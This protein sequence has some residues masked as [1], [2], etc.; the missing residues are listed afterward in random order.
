MKRFAEVGLAVRHLA[1][2]AT[3]AACGSPGGAVELLESETDPRLNSVLVSTRRAEPT[4]ELHSGRTLEPISQVSDFEP[5]LAEPAAAASADEA[6]AASE[7]QSEEQPG[8]ESTASASTASSK[9]AVSAPASPS[10]KTAS[11]PAKT[12]LT[13]AK[14]Q[15]AKTSSPPKTLAKDNGFTPRVATRVVEQP[16]TKSAGANGSTRP[17]RFNRV[18]PGVTTEDRLIVEW[19]EPADRSP[20]RGEL[21]GEV[22]TF[23]QPPF[24]AV[25]ALVRDG[26]V[27]V[28]RVTLAESSSIAD[29]TRKLK[30]S[31]VEPVDVIDPGA[32]TLLGVSFP[33]KGLTLLTGGR[34]TPGP[35]QIVKLVL[36]PRGPK[37]FTLRAENRPVTAIEKRLADLTAA[38][39]LDAKDPHAWWLKSLAHLDAGQ[40][41]DAVEAAVR[42]TEL[43]SKSAAYRLAE[44]RSLAIAGKLDA[45]VLTTRRVL[46]DGGASPIVRA[47]ALHTLGS[48]ASLGGASIAGKSIGFH[49]RAIE[50]ADELT[51]SR[52]P[53]VRRRAKRMLVD[54][55]LAIAVEI[56]RRD[57]KDRDALVADWIGRASG[58]AEAAIEAEDGGLELRLRVAREALTALA[59]MRPTK[60]PSP[61]ID[62]AKQTAEALLASSDDSLF[63]AGV[64]WDLGVAYKQAVR[65]EH[66]RADAAQALRFGSEAIDHLAEGAGPRVT[67]PGAERTVGELYFY[68]GAANAVH[69]EN[70]EE[71]VGW[72]E[73]ARPLVSNVKKSEF[74]V[75]RRTG[76]MLVSMGV[77]YWQRD[78]HDLAI[79]LTE[80]GAELMQQAIDA[81]VLDRPAIAV[82]YK[83][84]ASMHRALGESDKAT[85]YTRLARSARTDGSAAVAAE[86]AAPQPQASPV[87]KRQPTTQQQAEVSKPQRRSPRFTRRPTP[88]GTIRR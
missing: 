46:D 66:T 51:S 65:V 32:G 73:K 60:D 45:A 71:A 15:A 79:E 55:H 78:E 36:E 20:A 52:D 14:P 69:R 23:N 38:I 39:R 49:T 61:W 80:R 4:D 13:P 12:T 7:G 70:H 1:V 83:N 27:R 18:Q 2:V 81:G 16:T 44:A 59:A 10:A 31:E 88:R 37:A 6:A 8:S 35:A 54:A 68:L 33:E 28:V 77:S 48:L 47:E 63:R 64:E 57:Y 76:E 75:P 62:E 67:A 72:Y 58:L 21:S 82:P 9:P 85:Q 17:A 84:L 30:L 11:A 40:A 43:R 41:D 5:E 24:Q 26:L 22:L 34:P 74:V 87:A 19:G 42:A 56:A 86:P 50:I 25:E 53:R 29:L 3:I